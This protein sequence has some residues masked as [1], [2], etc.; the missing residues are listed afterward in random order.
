LRL[1]EDFMQQDF[2]VERFLEYAHRFH[3][4]ALDKRINLLLKVH[5]L[6]NVKSRNS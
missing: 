1:D 4:K 6:E 3:S 5:D 2:N